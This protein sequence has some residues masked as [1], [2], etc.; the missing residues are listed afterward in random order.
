MA[1]PSSPFGFERMN[2]LELGSESLTLS[3][4]F[5]VFVTGNVKNLKTKYNV[6]G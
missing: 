3:G 6:F 4:E 2:G 5:K 1:S